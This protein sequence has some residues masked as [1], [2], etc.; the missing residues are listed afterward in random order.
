MQKVSHGFVS[1]YGYGMALARLWCGVWYTFG[2]VSVR[3]LH[4]SGKVGMVL[5]W[6]F[7][8]FAMAWQ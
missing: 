4:G 5:L 3:F 1:S 2:Q 8:G 6:L 7:Y